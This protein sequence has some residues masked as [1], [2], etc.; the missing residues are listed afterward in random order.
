MADY[1]KNKRSLQNYIWNLKSDIVLNYQLTKHVFNNID[2]NKTLDEVLL[3]IRET[4][5]KYASTNLSEVQIDT[6]YI[7]NDFPISSLQNDFLKSRVQGSQIKAEMDK[8][9]SDFEELKTISN[10]EEYMKKALD[11]FQRF[12]Q[13][14]PY[15]DG[16]GRTSRY[17]LN[18]M[19]AAKNIVPPVL[20]DTYMDRTKLDKLSNEFALNGNKEPLYDYVISLVNEQALEANHDNNQPVMNLSESVIKK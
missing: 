6:K 13:I 1:L 4:F 3:G 5:S 18:Y 2:N 16:N 12:V 11:I 7:E 17:L 10:N 14:H 15:G 9:N 8:L 19:F 20:Y